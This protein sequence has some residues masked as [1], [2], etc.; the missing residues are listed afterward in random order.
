[1]SKKQ[2][3]APSLPDGSETTLNAAID[4]TET[5]LILEALERNEY[6]RRAAA[7]EL[8]MHKT[9]LFRKLHRLGI[10]LPARDG[11]SAFVKKVYSC[12]SAILLLYAS[13]IVAVLQS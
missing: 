3:T 1:L 8:G 4:S 9:T 7:E 2:G 12:N 13:V 5:R 6:N 11:R 10:K